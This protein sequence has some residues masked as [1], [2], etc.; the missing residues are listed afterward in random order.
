MDQG[1]MLLDS[2]ILILS[3]LYNMQQ[4]KPAH[5]IPKG[6]WKEHPRM[7]SIMI[8]AVLLFILAIFT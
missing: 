1:L 6:Y 5:R 2:F 4:I 3:I 8:F 7:R